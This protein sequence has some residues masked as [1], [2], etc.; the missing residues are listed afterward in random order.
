MAEGVLKSLFGKKDAPAPAGIAKAVPGG[1]TLK[2]GQG[3]RA[4]VLSM[5]ERGETPLSMAEW[6][7]GAEAPKS[8]NQLT[9]K[10]R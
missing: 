9:D 1:D 2:K 6:M 5:Q 4:Y 3:Y 8:T 7:A 10:L